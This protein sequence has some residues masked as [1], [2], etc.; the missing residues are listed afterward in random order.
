MQ[1]LTVEQHAWR[2]HNRLGHPPVDKLVETLKFHGLLARRCDLLTKLY[3]KCAVCNCR[4]KPA[5]PIRPLD[6][7]TQTEKGLA[8]LDLTEPSTRGN[9]GYR[10]ISV[11]IDVHSKFLSARAC[12]NRTDAICH[13]GNFL[14]K[15][16]HIKTLRVDGAAE[17]HGQSMRTLVHKHGVALQRTAPGTGQSIGAVERA[18]RTIKDKITMLMLSLG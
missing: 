10:Y 6:Q 14:R 5:K 15:N 16:I 3:A 11:I 9:G 7:M 8:M 2:L 18:H 17:F 1:R 4:P 12:I 13:V